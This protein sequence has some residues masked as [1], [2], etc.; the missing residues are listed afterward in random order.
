[1]KYPY[2]VAWYIHCFSNVTK[3]I[4]NDFDIY[5]TIKVQSSNLLFEYYFLGNK[6]NEQYE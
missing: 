4:L 1:M 2:N 6:S 3:P 5:N